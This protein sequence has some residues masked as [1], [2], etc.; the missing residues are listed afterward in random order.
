MEP[1]RENKEES[2]FVF[3]NTLYCHIYEYFGFVLEHKRKDFQGLFWT[4]A[5]LSP[6]HRWLLEK[7]KIPMSVV[8]KFLKGG[9]NIELSLSYLLTFCF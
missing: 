6:F 3:A 9:I 2:G 7:E 8:K 4:A 5:Y 1:I